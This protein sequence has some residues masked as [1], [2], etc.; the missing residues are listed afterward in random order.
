M[1]MEL[2][3]GVQGSLVAGRR[4]RIRATTGLLDGTTGW[5][6]WTGNWCEG[7]YEDFYSRLRA[8]LRLRLRHEELGLHVQASSR[9]GLGLGVRL[10]LGIGLGVC[11]TA[12]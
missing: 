6:Y 7:F 9:K 4:I 5:D 8:T 2:E 1:R 10:G 12:L 3:L 11:G